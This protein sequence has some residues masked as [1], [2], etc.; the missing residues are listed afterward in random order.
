MDKWPKVKGSHL[1]ILKFELHGDD[2]PATVSL[3]IT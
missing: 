2:C 1:K 3:E